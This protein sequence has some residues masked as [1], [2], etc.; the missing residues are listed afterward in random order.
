MST[1]AHF[2][3][4]NFDTEV[5]KSKLPVLVDFFAD[6]CGPC[7]AL[8]PIV[9][10][11]AKDFAGKVKIGKV[12]VDASAEVPGRYAIRAVPTLILFKNGL[13]VEQ[14]TGLLPKADLRK[15]LEAVLAG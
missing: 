15:K 3:D 2:D 1:L 5:L 4:A 8:T 14:I 12:D 13:V 11:L 6:W 10:Q 7:K 9:E